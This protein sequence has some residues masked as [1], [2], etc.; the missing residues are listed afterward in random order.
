MSESQFAA[1]RTPTTMESGKVG[2]GCLI[3]IGFAVVL[4]ILVAMTVGQYNGLVD[5]QEKTRKHWQEVDNQYKRR[6]DLVGNLV[7]TVKGAAAFNKDTLVE[8]TEARASV[9]RVQL[10]SNLPTDP[11]AMQAYV[12]AQQQLG[13]A[14]SRLLMTVEAYPD[15]KASSNFS[16]LQVQLEGT[17]NRIAVARRD[18]LDAAQ[19]YNAATRRFPANFLAGMFNFERAAELPVTAEERAVPRVNFG[20]DGAK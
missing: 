14:L 15:L 7:E 10:P 16:D 8:V 5:K 3:G 12:N 2:K 19:D 1:K 20:G 9:S 11:A 6:S 13:G 17:E 18:Y 4:A